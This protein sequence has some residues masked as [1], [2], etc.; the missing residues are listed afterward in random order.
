MEALKEA[1]MSRNI[2]A[3]GIVILLVVL[4]LRLLKSATQGFVILVV[5]FALLFVLYR[6]FPGVS[7]PLVDFVKG[8]WLGDQRYQ[9]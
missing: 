2:L 3:W 1:L 6:F 8:G 9:P 7:A 5:I 4:V